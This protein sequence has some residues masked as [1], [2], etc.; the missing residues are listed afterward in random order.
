MTTSVRLHTLLRFA[1]AAGILGATLV[2]A[3]P[4]FATSPSTSASGIVI[5]ASPTRHTLVVTNNGVVHTWRVASANV[6]LGKIVSAATTPLG[7]GTFQATA[8]VVKGATS[9][10]RVSA[11]VVSSSTSTLVLSAGASTFA[12]VVPH[13]RAAHTASSQPL[14]GS[15]VTVT[16]TV[17][18]SFLDE[19]AASVSSSTNMISL[20]GTVSALSATSL[21]LAV[22]NGSSTVIAIPA[23]VTVPSSV[24]VGTLVQAVVVFDG[25][26]FTLATLTT[27]AAAATQGTSGVCQENNGQ[28]AYVGIE[29]QVVAADATTIIIQPGNG[30]SPVIVTIPANVTVPSVTIGSFVHVRATTTNGTLTLV[31]LAVHSAQGDEHN[32]GTETLGV[33][34]AVSSSSLTIQPRG[35]ATPVVFVV[36]STVDVSAV[37]V[38]D[39]VRASGS[40]ASGTLTLSAFRD[41][42]AVPG[43]PAQGTGVASQVDGA[44]TAVSATSLSLQPEDGAAVVVIAVPSSVDVSAIAVGDEV[45]ASTTLVS[46]VVTLVSFNDH[47]QRPASGAPSGPI[48][49]AGSG[50]VAS[51]SATQL[52]LTAGDRG[53]QVTIVVPSTVDVSSLSTGMRVG[54]IATYG[55]GTYTLV[56][57]V[58]PSNNFNPTAPQGPNGGPQGPQ[59]VAAFGTVTSVSPTQIVLTLPNTAV[60][61]VA[62]PSTVDVSSVTVGQSLAI[63]ASV[64]NGSVTLIAINPQQRDQHGNR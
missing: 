12:V 6:T 1:V 28:S 14:V 7:D 10:V 52:V 37:N 39:L 55:A 41:L 62:V 22:Q 18:G 15:D 35:T 20:E 8:V 45:R 30:A 56:R 25:T 29:G 2:S 38:G 31:S 5:A 64:S 13:A 21:T 54:V 47:G 50:I 26:T 3:A 9:S 11:T 23:S 46:G 48:Q 43:N 36:P 40:L 33:V 61:T 57:F 59:L 44:V 19:T 60:L 58:V 51:V 63:S 24:V 16:A 32:G 17:A 53:A 4:A 49:V 27:D 42:G 34:V